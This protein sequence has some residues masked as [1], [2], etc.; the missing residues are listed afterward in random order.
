M[1]GEKGTEQVWLS[2]SC[3]GIVEVPTLREQEALKS[4]R[5]IK[6]RVRKLKQALDETAHASGGQ[7]R[8]SIE[9]ELNRLKEEWNHWEKERQEA[10]KERMILLGH[11]EA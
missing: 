7:K 10:A 8:D 4:L 11:E 9:R 6:T 5:V 3:A 2:A 1:C